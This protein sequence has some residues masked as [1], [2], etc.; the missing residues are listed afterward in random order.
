MN[1]EKTNL[2]AESP[3]LSKGDVGHSVVWK[4]TMMLRWID[5]NKANNWKNSVKFY[6]DIGWGNPNHVV[7]QQMWLGDLGEQDWR[8]IEVGG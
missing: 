6:N 7:L 8:D 2:E 5:G 4:P 3:A 1:T